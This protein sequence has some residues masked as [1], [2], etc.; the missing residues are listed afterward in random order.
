LAM[1]VGEG[2]RVAILPIT[3]GDEKEMLAMIDQL[4]VNNIIIESREAN[5][6]NELQTVRA[7]S[8]GLTFRD[9]RAIKENIAGIELITPRKRF[10]PQKAL[11][12]TNQEL[13]QVFGVLPNYRDINT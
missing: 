7:I 8:P 6:P 5:D 4:G 12:K 1:F 9:Y 3:A 13:P 10:K 2:A 11:P